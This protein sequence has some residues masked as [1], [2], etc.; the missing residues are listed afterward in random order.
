MEAV[1][2]AGERLSRETAHTSLGQSTSAAQEGTDIEKSV[3]TM[4]TLDIFTM[5]P[6]ASTVQQFPCHVY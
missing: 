6:K 1:W 4:R 5:R 3:T 2:L